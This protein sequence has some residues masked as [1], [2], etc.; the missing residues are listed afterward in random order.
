MKNAL[1]KWQ[2][3]AA[4]E[5]TH[6]LLTHCLWPRILINADSLTFV[7]G[8][9]RDYYHHVKRLFFPNRSIQFSYSCNAV[10]QFLC[11]NLERISFH[12][13]HIKML[14]IH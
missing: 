6:T 4:S 3:K 9:Q 10:I 7:E 12:H 1:D 5:L 8:T 2:L 13:F 11:S 14:N